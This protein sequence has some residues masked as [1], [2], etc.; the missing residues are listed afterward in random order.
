MKKLEFSIDIAA[1][2]EKVWYALWNDWHYRQWVKAFS[3]GSYALK[4]WQQ[5]SDVQFLNASGNGIYSEIESME[6]YETMLFKHIGEVKKHKKM[7]VDEASQNWTGMNE[8]YHLSE[9]STGTTLK[10][11]IETLEAFRDYFEINFPKA[12]ENIKTQAE[13]LYVFTS[14]VINADLIDVWEKFLQPDHIQQ[15][16]HA[17]DDWHTTKSLCDVQPN[18][19]FL[20]RMEAKDGSFGFDF[21][22]VYSDVQ[23]HKRIAYTMDDGRKAKIDFVKEGNCI[24]INQVFQPESINNIELQQ[25]GWQLILNNFKKYCETKN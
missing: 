10:V 4:D 3:D 16:N 23:L 2:K 8:S 19:K 5:G 15:W 22:G 14:A 13:K 6:L 18:G 9:D 11:K 20:F 24:L 17:N 7:P 12:L 21:S 25:M 1:S